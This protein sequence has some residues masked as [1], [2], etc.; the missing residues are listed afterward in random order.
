MK[1][2]FLI[3]GLAIFLG[4][5]A[6]A[7]TYFFATATVCRMPA[8]NDDLS[9][10]TREFHLSSEQVAKIKILN[11][12]YRPKCLALCASIASADETLKKLVLTNKTVTPEVQAALDQETSV[13]MQCHEHLLHYCYEVSQTMAP[14]QGKRYLQLMQSCLTEDG[15]PADPSSTSCQTHGCH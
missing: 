3:L 9:W 11:D 13:R 5:A 15:K 14:D 10:L 1:R 8:S 4:L 2:V 12:Q 7:S 6:Y